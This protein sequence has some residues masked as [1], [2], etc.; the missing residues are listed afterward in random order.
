MLQAVIHNV[1]EIAAEVIRKTGKDKPADAARREVLKQ[2]K[3]AEAR[4]GRAAG[5]RVG[6]MVEQ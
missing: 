3:D 6:F 5:E 1:H 2:I 4:S